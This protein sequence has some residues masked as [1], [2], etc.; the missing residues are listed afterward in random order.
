MNSGCFACSAALFG[1]GVGSGVGVF[2]IA[3][4]SSIS[5]FVD[6]IIRDIIAVVLD[7]NANAGR[8][9]FAK[10]PSVDML[11]TTTT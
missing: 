5:R 8:S 10:N 3:V 7:S 1:A 11:T 6:R 4:L 9:G 2:Q